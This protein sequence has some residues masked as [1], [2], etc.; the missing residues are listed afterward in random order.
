MQRIPPDV[1]LVAMS[2]ADGSIAIMQF[3]TRQHPYRGDPGWSR[4]AT[5]AA[6]QAEIRRAGLAPVSWARIDKDDLPSDRSARDAW[7]WD[8]EKVVVDP[9]RIKPAAQAMRAAPA[10]AVMQDPRVDALG[11]QLAGQ[12]EAGFR[13]MAENLEARLQEIKA[14]TLREAA[15]ERRLGLEA[16]VVSSAI[17][18][19]RPVEPGS[20]PAIE[21]RLAKQ[22]RPITS[23][24]I[25]AAAD[26][27]G[28]REIEQA[29][30]VR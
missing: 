21:A 3:V 14:E 15:I 10:G 11:P 30:G 27:Q 4:D 28:R 26:E 22:G 13:A 12:I 24:E 2:M 9:S 7:V 29:R 19:K 6:I 18:E 1:Q 16:L 8:G 5:D 20:Y 25:I 17:A 23:E